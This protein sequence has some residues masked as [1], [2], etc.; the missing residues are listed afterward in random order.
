MEI[1]K[2]LSINLFSVNKNTHQSALSRSIRRLEQ[3]VLRMGTRVEESFRLSHQCLFDRNLDAV[4]KIKDLE[5]QIDEYYRQIELDCVNIIALKTPVARDL[6]L[7][8]AY[9]QLIVDLERI[10]DY[11]VEI[12]QIAIKLF[13]Y[14]SHPCLK[15]IEEMSDRAQSMLDTS[16]VALADMDATIASN[17][18]TL[19]NTINLAYDRLY[20][21]LAH[22]KDIKGVVE[23]ILL[24]GLLICHL[25]KM[26]DHAANIG[27]RVSYIV[28]GHHNY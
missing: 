24:L 1:D 22:Q 23:P 10:G 19:D 3:D 6:R 13:S 5:K 25:E 16:L 4:T 28:T 20:Q 21:V 17:L 9:M 26:A 2:N 14:P 18:K 8:S 27:Q 12:S 7:I 11:A 15:E